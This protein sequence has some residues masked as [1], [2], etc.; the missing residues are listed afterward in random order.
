[1]TEYEQRALADAEHWKITLLKRPS[2][3]QRNAK[4]LQNKLNKKV[5]E[6]IHKIITESIKKM[7]ETTIIGSTITTKKDYNRHLSFEEREA[8]IKATISKYRKTAA[9]EGAGTGAG[10][11]LLGAADFPL[12]LSIKMKCLFDIATI[13]GFDVRK[14][15]ERLFILYIFHLAFC[16]EEKRTEVFALIQ[17]WNQSSQHN[18]DWKSFQQEYR[19]YIDV[20]KMLQLMPGFGAF[21]GAFANYHLLDHVTQVAM[22]VYRLRLLSSN[23]KNLP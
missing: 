5:P 2:A 10:G 14:Q 17:E 19:D 13:Y 12:F 11:L 6:S 4:Q 21:V 8:E 23:E 7:V 22:N 1:M 9:V 20:I 18:L 16:S 15:D 3:F